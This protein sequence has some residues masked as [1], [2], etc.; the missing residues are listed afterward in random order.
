LT[1]PDPIVVAANT[2]GA[3]CFNTTAIVNANV[4]GGVQPYTYLLNGVARDTGI[5]TN[6]PHGDYLLL[7]MDVNGCQGKVS[8]NVTAPAA[9]NVDLTATQQVILTGMETQLVATTDSGAVILHY[10]WMPDTLF[11]MGSCEDCYNPYVAPRT[12]TI[13]TV[14]VMNSDSCYASDTITIYVDNE[15]SKFVPTAFT[16]NGDGL[17]DKFEFD[18]LGVSEIE[19]SIYNRWGQKVYYNPNQLNG[20]TS[21]SGWDGMVDGKLATYDTYVYSIRVTYW[22]DVPKDIAGTVTLM[23]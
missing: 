17:N 8:F 3:N 19:V 23:K 20:T 10:A 6:L 22:D 7:V 16:P 2:Q 9:I 12:T 11:G 13:F 5:F 14:T 21:G 4:T 15:A 18:I 1:N